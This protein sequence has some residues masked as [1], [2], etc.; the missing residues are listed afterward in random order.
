MYG[1]KKGSIVILAMVILLSIG[2]LQAKE[3]RKFNSQT[4]DEIYASIRHAPA[5][6]ETTSRDV[7]F[8]NEGMK[9]I[10][11]LT[12]PNVNMKVPV[13]LYLNGYAGDRNEL[14]F[15]DGTEYIW[16]RLSR[17]M[18]EHGIASLRIDFRGS[19]DSDGTFEIATFST[20][21]SDAMAALKFIR[22]SLR[23]EVD[24]KSIGV[25]GFS[26]GGLV[27]S[28]ATARDGNVDS[29]L[30]WSPVSNPPMVYEGLFTK[31]GMKQGL[32][33]AE[34]ES[35]TLGIYFDDVYIDWDVA[36]GK[37][38]FENIFQVQP[39]A[40]ISKNYDG[41]LMALCGS[42]DMVIWPQPHQSDLYLTNH[43]GFEKLVFLEGADHAFNWWDGAE[44]EKF[45][46]AIYWSAAWFLHTLN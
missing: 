15:N 17:I 34:G 23:K 2:G 8:Q 37:K 33:L 16:Q 12:V 28:C 3:A 36:M 41:P 5:K 7:T 1:I 30:L 38:F 43:D 13:V 10:G 20:Q 14:I 29:L 6:Y 11:T 26:Q 35:I 46:D 25:L 40:E 39:V 44:P 19:G 22:K 45:H 32:A 24:W 31:A 9:L 18:A 21:I 27:G 42:N 4:V